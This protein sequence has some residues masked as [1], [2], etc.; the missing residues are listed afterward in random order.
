M[1]PVDCVFEEGWRKAEA[2]TLSWRVDFG[3]F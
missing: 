2:W 1:G 3:S